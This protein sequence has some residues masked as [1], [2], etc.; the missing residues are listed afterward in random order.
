MRFRLKESEIPKSKVDDIKN[1]P[2]PRTK[3]QLEKFLGIFAF[4]HKFVKNA[5]AI[6]APLHNL[7]TNTKNDKD[8]PEAIF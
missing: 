6:I 2:V 8:L 5:S 7:Q 1:Y 3:K 4:V